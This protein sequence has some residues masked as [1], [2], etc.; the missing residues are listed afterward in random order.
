MIELLKHQKEFIEAKDMEVILLGDE[1][2]G[3]SFAQYYDAVEY[4]LIH[5]QTGQLFVSDDPRR[6][7]DLLTSYVEKLYVDIEKDGLVRPYVEWFTICFKTG[8][9]IL[10]GP[11]IRN[12]KDAFRHSGADYQTIRIDTEIFDM[13]SYVYCYMLSRLKWW[14]KKWP[15]HMKITAKDASYRLVNSRKMRVIEADYCYKPPL[16]KKPMFTPFVFDKTDPEFE[17]IIKKNEVDYRKHIDGEWPEI[18]EE[19]NL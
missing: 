8:S 11:R 7:V 4:A 12:E 10:L 3:K 13:D 16:G 5:P 17:K 9:K 14:G 18:K 6:S 19:N 15:L 2:T 1:A